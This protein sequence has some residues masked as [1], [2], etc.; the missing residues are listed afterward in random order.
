MMMTLSGCNSW[1][2]HRQCHWWWH[3]LYFLSTNTTMTLTIS[4][5]NNKIEHFFPFSSSV[6]MMTTM[7]S[8]FAC[9]E[10]S[11]RHTLIS[12]L[13][14]SSFLISQFFCIERLN[15]AGTMLLMRF[16]LEIVGYLVLSALLIPVSIALIGTSAGTL[17]SLKQC[18]Q[19]GA[20]TYISGR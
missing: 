6:M 1:W 2:C 16:L 9:F 12:K 3:R 14:K 8:I 13:G 7:M 5:I 15:P 17:A 4:L 11:R 19:S 10:M 20:R 18:R